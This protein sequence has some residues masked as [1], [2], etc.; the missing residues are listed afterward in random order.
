[1]TAKSPSYPAYLLAR[2][3]GRARRLSPVVVLGGLVHPPS[4]VIYLPL[5]LMG[6]SRV[7]QE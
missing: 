7:K 6:C 5:V 3:A 2:G 4:H 1:M